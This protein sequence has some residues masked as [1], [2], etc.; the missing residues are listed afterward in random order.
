[1]QLCM[2]ECVDMS[3]FISGY[4]YNICTHVCACGQPV[5]SYSPWALEASR[6]DSRLEPGHTAQC[7]GRRRHGLALHLVE[8]DGLRGFGADLPKRCRPGI[9]LEVATVFCLFW[10]L[11]SP[12]RCRE[13]QC[14]GIGMV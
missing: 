13:I 1:M 4:I 10:G 6:R 5:S 7:Q 11:F 14:F 2:S 12:I 8:D 9:V 3:I